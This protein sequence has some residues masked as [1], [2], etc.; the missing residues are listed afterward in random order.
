M[1]IPVLHDQQTDNLTNDNG[2]FSWGRCSRPSSAAFRSSE[3]QL[4]ATHGAEG[5]AARLLGSA[6]V[7]LENYQPNGVRRARGPRQR[8]SFFIADMNDAIDSGN[9]GAGRTVCLGSYRWRHSPE[10]RYG[11]WP[12]RRQSGSLSHPCLPP[13]MDQYATGFYQAVLPKAFWAGRSPTRNSARKQST[14]RLWLD[15]FRIAMTGRS[16]RAGRTGWMT[17]RRG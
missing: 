7:I 3:D 6:S 16:R 4:G 11:T 1:G 14:I 15:R 12:A 10:C 9:G 17:T 2:G 8:L 13:G 5:R